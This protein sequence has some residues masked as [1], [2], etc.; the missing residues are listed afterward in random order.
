MQRRELPPPQVTIDGTRERA[1]T[2]LGY[3][4]AYSVTL[5]T[6]LPALGLELHS[7]YLG[8]EQTPTLAGHLALAPHDRR[9]R[10]LLHDPGALPVAG[11]PAPSPARAAAARCCSTT[12]PS[13]APTSAPSPAPT[14]SASTSTTPPYTSSSTASSPF[15]SSS[16]AALAALV[17]QGVTLHTSDG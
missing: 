17:E 3:A 13:C 9:V 1:S 7:T 12:S 5:S 11:A 2:Q 16:A 15:L 6:T 4:G 10:H 8:H 14:T